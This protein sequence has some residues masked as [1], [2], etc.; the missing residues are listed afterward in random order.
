MQNRADISAE[1]TS[2]EGQPGIALVLEGQT[3]I[4]PT[5]TL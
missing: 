2:S 5:Y 1:L 4:L 3:Y